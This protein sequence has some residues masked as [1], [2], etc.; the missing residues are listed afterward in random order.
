MRFLAAILL[1]VFATSSAIAANK[2]W[3]NARNWKGEG[4]YVTEY[5]N[6]VR[7][8]LMSGPFWSEKGCL[9][10]LEEGVHDYMEVSGLT[11]E[12]ENYASR[13]PLAPKRSDLVGT[14]RCGSTARGPA[15]DVTG[16]EELN[17]HPDGTY[18]SHATTLISE[19]GKA[20][21]TIEERIHGAWRLEGDV[22]VSRVLGTEVLSTT[23]PTM[24]KA[25][26]Q[27]AKD[28]QLI[29][30]SLFVSRIVELGNGHMRSILIHPELKEM[31]VE[32]SCQRR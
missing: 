12:C 7:S 28:Y 1:L 29:L 17:R 10:E 30:M 13:T 24:T 16:I 6:N 26:L 4:W 2:P 15:S 21:I 18:T 22:E 5:A 9:E 3:K 32:S 31:S 20:P 25:Q 27:K 8:G 11:Y 14:W 19:P 23:H